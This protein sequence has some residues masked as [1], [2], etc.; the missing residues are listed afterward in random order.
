MFIKKIIIDEIK[1][2]NKNPNIPIN[3]ISFIFFCL[4]KITDFASWP[5]PIMV[6]EDNI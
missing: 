6:N 5:Y 2:K 3:P 4:V 1:Y